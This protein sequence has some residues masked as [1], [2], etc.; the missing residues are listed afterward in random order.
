MW[1]RELDLNGLGAVAE[2]YR[3]GAK[4]LRNRALTGPVDYEQIPALAER[5]QLRVRRFFL[6]TARCNTA[7]PSRAIG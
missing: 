6:N 4:G 3:N 5:G 2:C 7:N 1:Q